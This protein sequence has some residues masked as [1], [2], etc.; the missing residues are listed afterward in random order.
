MRAYIISNVCKNASAIFP[1][2]IAAEVYST[3]FNQSQIPEIATL[4]GNPNK[5]TDA[6]PRYASV[7]YK[8]GVIMGGN[9]LGS[10]AIMKVR[11]L[12]FLNVISKS[13][14]RYSKPYSVGQ[15]QLLTPL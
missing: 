3:T 10:V 2:T 6:H 1:I 12:P 13:F 11:W 5:P 14:Y 8:D 7:L 15:H 4:L 9:L